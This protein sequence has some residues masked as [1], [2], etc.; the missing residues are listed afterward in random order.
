MVELLVELQLEQ[1]R[2]VKLHGAQFDPDQR[3]NSSSLCIVQIFTQNGDYRST[4]P[5]YHI[6]DLYSTRPIIITTPG[7]LR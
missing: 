7:V 1:G 6:D 2:G 5:F 3:K 4:S